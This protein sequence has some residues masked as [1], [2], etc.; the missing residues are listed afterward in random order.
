MSEIPKSTYENEER[1]AARRFIGHKIHEI[2][3]DVDIDRLERAVDIVDSEEMDLLN[4]LPMYDLV[5]ADEQDARRQKQTDLDI[6]SGYN[7]APPSVTS[8][9]VE[10]MKGEILDN[11]I[12]DRKALDE[13]VNELATEM[14]KAVDDRE[15]QARIGKRLDDVID[16]YSEK[17]LD[18]QAKEDLNN[19]VDAQITKALDEEHEVRPAAVTSEE[20]GPEL[21]EFEALRAELDALKKRVDEGEARVAYLR[22]GLQSIIAA[23][24]DGKDMRSVAEQVATGYED[25]VNGDQPEPAKA[26]DT[27]TQPIPTP[28]AKQENDQELKGIRRF[29][30]KFRL[31]NPSYHN[32]RPDV[33]G[34]VTNISNGVR[35][36]LKKR[37]NK[38]V[39]VP[40][41]NEQQEKKLKKRTL[42]IAGIGLAAVATAVVVAA[43]GPDNIGDY[44][45]S[46]D[47]PSWLG[48]DETTHAHKVITEPTID[49]MTVDI[50]GD[51]GDT[52]GLTGAEGDTSGAT[53]EAASFS[54]EAA[55][56]TSGEGWI[57]T[58][59]EMG[60]PQS[61]QG[62]ILQ[63]LLESNDPSIQEWVYDRGGEPGITKTGQIPAEV[64][65][66]I[67]RL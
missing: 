22:E 61:E 35:A 47:W 25:F 63:K 49:Q 19:K 17:Y 13:E 4:E 55:T 32:S 50:G 60:I 14:A 29:I 58:L 51:S 39:T 52:S 46:I 41:L 37:G 54:T 6:V 28:E 8:E 48:G 21:S 67:S 11:Y 34:K 57:H 62:D 38:D 10:M 36:Y 44:A 1:L 66:K 40:L 31:L 2:F 53:E 45:A 30:S 5:L 33:R 15:A 24:E 56:V 16:Q 42:V 65:E 7:I 26:E 12:K 64:L 20:E 59:N 18:A 3:R 23:D 27:P 9:E 43:G